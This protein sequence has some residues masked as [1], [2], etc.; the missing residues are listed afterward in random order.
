M[1]VLESLTEL[2]KLVERSPDR[3]ELYVRWSR[4]PDADL[5]GV[6]G[7]EQRSIDA[8]TGMKLPGLSANPLRVEQWWGRRSV[9]LWVARRLFDY[10]HLRE[11]R[12]SGTRPWVF[13]GEERGRGP[14]NEPL[15]LCRR[16]IAW[17]ADRALRESEELIESQQSAEWGS[18]R[19]S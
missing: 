15:V 16:P 19:R 10:R 14:D 6:H 4:G 8:L 12:G 18:L 9:R 1:D 5:E 7:D 11:Q 3:D 13:V 2:A 17:V